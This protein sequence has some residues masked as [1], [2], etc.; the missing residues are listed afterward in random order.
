[1]KQ[2]ALLLMAVFFCISGYLSGCASAPPE[3]PWAKVTSPL[4]GAPRSIGKPGAGCWS[5]RNHW[6]RTDRVIG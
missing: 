2:I 1:M 3:N 6:I 5:E 4:A